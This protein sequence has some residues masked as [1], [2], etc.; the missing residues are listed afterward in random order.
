MPLSSSTGRTGRHWC[1]LGNV[2][3][4]PTKASWSWVFPEPLMK[5]AS[6]DRRR[7]LLRAHGRHCRLLFGDGG[8]GQ[9]CTS[10]FAARRGRCRARRRQRHFGFAG[11]PQELEGLRHRDG[12]SRCCRNGYCQHC[13]R[14]RVR[15]PWL[16][17]DLRLLDKI[18]LLRP[19]GLVCRVRQHLLRLH[20]VLQPCL[21][22]RLLFVLFPCPSWRGRWRHLAL[23]GRR[24]LRLRSPRNR[25]R[26]GARRGLPNPDSSSVLF[27]RPPWQRRVASATRRR[28]PGGSRTR[29]LWGEQLGLAVS[30]GDGPFPP[31]GRVEAHD[32]L[33]LPQWGRSP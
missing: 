16:L 29:A 23:G 24:R 28:Q 17:C 30:N 26:R 9:H 14:G 5:L 4:L 10:S 22:L 12:G 32:A 20:L 15:L 2:V 1:T 3:G 8:R 11:S 33:H 27:R 13:G 6:T 31:F 19:C 18:L 21:Q 25:W 7:R